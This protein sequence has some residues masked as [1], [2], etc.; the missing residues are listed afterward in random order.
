MDQAV[1]LPALNGRFIDGIFFVANHLMAK[2]PE[3]LA[4]NQCSFCLIKTKSGG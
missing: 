2:L 4:L 3:I 1:G